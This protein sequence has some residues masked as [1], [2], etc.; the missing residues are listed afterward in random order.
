MDRDLVGYANNPPAVTWPGGARIAISLVVNYEEGSENLL[1]DGVGRREMMGEAPSPVPADRRDLALESMFE[2]GSRVGVWRL[3]R[4]FEKYG[5]KS[6]FFACAVALERNPELA[7][8]I[9]PAG[10]DLCGHGNRWEEYYLM[11]REAERRAIHEGYATIERTTGQPP[12]GWYCRYGPS[13]HT[14]ELVVEH[15]GFLYDSNA[16][17]D[18]LPYYTPVG[19]RPWL[20]VPYS[21]A[22][23]D[24]RF[25]RGYYASGDDFFQSAKETFDTLYEEGATTPKM[26]SLGLHCRIAGWPG[27]ANGLD[28]F[29]A[30][31]SGHE[32]V[33]WAGRSEIARW[34][35]E[36]QPP[37][38]AAQ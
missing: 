2:Y 14:R 19:E 20:V 21:M 4:I 15:G 9:V 24:M 37:G 29:I 23:N 33:W 38:Q 36:H 28:R 34:W 13:E 10:H 6:T 18:D 26:M 32:G 8:A 11:D 27:R 22:L 31:A 1:Q 17:N 12:L 7:R 25:W 3:L 35:L 16:Y 5:V 30:Y